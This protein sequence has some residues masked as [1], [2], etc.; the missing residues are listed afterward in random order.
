MDQ[1]DYW[2]QRWAEKKTGWDRGDISPA[3][4]HWF[5]DSTALPRRILVPGC[6]NGYE[7]QWLARHGARVTAVDIVPEP[8]DAL[9][10]RLQAQ[11]LSAELVLADLFDWEPDEP[12]DAIYEQTC[13][14]AITKDQRQAYA[15]RLYRWL[16]PGGVL[17]ALFAQTPWR[18]GPP[19][20]CDLE[21]MRQDLFSA[22]RWDWPA[23]ADF[24]VP[25]E[26]GFQEH[27]YRLLRR[28]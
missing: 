13:L 10:Q 15:E 3:T 27:G 24:I 8:L 14:C 22:E 17:Y 4:E 26:A 7:V 25:H 21:E 19:W 6:G 1:A 11:D 12:F 20:H 16:K 5:A 23:Q 28:T 2:K 9:R 18:N